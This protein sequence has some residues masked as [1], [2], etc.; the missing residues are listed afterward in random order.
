[1][2]F[3]FPEPVEVAGMVIYWAWNSYSSSWMCSQ[4]YRLQY[5]DEGGSFIDIETVYN[6][7]V[8]SISVALFD[9]TITSS[10]IRYYQPANRGPSNYP[11]V[12]WLTE[13]EIYGEMGI[14][15]PNP[16]GTE[17]ILEDSSAM[18]IANPVNAQRPVFYEF[19]L[20]VDST[21][22]DPRI[23]PPLIIDTV[24]STTYDNLSAEYYYYWRC[25]A[26][27]SDL[28][29][30]SAWSRSESFNLILSAAAEV[31]NIR[32]RNLSTVESCYQTF[33]IRF[34]PISDFIY[35]EVDDNPDFT[36]PLVS[37]PIG[38]NNDGLASWQPDS[39]EIS[40]EL[41][42]NG[43][44]YWRASADNA[45]WSV[46]TV[47]VSLDIHAYPVPFRDSDGHSR[48]TFTN[49]PENSK[50]I[51]A[52]VSGTVVFTESG[53]GPGEWAW[54]VRN[55]KGRGLASGVYLYAVD[56]EGGSAKGKIVVIR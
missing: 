32:P 46:F 10:R 13:M 14:P 17:I 43:V 16:I 9:T 29:D 27:A 36:S 41:S 53:V 24:I 54:D 7:D 1:V 11:A 39:A 2:E 56:S 51:V 23:E 49:L 30:T 34:Y 15:A 48:I 6:P 21:Y 45:E 33:E 12:V 3:I 52:S 5:R 40:S 26:I 28:S 37:G 4:E 50:I 19:A 35:F 44:Y 22:P 38:T 20:D 18:V 8:D 42:R 55:D 31:T 25:R 47:T